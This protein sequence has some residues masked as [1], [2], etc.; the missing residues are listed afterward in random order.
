MLRLLDC[1]K[2]GLRVFG[3]AL[4]G[5]SVTGA[6]RDICDKVI[7]LDRVAGGARDDAAA[8]VLPG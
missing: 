8:E 5:G 2:K 1:K 7:D 6:M 3:L 4:N